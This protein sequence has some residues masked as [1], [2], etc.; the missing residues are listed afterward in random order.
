M[1]L[2]NI[3]IPLDPANDFPTDRVQMPADKADPYTISDAVKHVCLDGPVTPIR[4]GGKA[5]T[6]NDVLLYDNLTDEL[7]G[8]IE[9]K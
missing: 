6:S 8:R 5:N 7:K 3:Y 9:L 2:L 1:P 4:S